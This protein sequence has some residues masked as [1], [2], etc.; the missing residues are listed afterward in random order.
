MVSDPPA[1]LGVGWAF[2]V[3][4]RADGTPAMVAHEED[5]R[6]SI[7]IIL[8]TEPGE[9]VMRPA[10][11]AGLR[12]FVFEPIN[13]GTMIRLGNRVRDALVDFEARIDVLDVSVTSDTE[14]RNR[15]LIDI[16]YRVRRTNS[17]YNLVYPFYL[18]EGAAS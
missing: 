12:S 9:R 13:P 3:G 14:E 15:L 17:L 4:L 8:G 16:S 11:G 1:F 18:D 10:F 2:S 7:R 5:I 6:Q